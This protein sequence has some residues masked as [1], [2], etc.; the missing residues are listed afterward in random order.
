MKAKETNF[1]E[2][3][4]GPKQLVIPIY[5]RTYSWTRKQCQQL[6]DDMLRVATRDDIPAHFIGSVVYISDGIYQATSIPRLLVIDG[7][8]RLTTLSLLLSALAKEMDTR[9]DS[10]AKRLR[11]YFLINNDE[12]NEMRYKLIL[13]RSDKDTYIQIIEGIKL[14]ER[15]SPH[16]HENYQFFENLIRS[17]NDDLNTLYHGISKLVI[18]DVSLNRDYDNPQLI[19]ESLNSTGLD[20]SQA[21]LIRNF[22]LM[23]LEGAQQDYLYSHYW[24]PMEHNFGHAQY[25]EMFDRF[26][27]DYLTIKSEA[28]EI[29]A[30]RNVYSEFKAYSRGKN[31]NELVEDI[32]T[33]SRYF[34]NLAFPDRIADKEI[35]TILYDINTLKVDVAYP[36]L[37]EMYHDYE[38]TGLLTREGFIEILLLVESYVLR[39][40]ICGIPAN[41]MNKTFATLK[42]SIRKDDYLNSVKYALLRLSG[43]RRFPLDEEFWHTFG[44]TDV[45]NLR[46]RRNYILSKL[47][48]HNRKEFVNVESYT[49]EHIMPQNP[50]LSE[51][52]RAALGENWKELHHKYLHTIGNLTLTG[53]NPELSDKPFVFKR[54]TEGGFADSPIRLNRDLAHLDTWN[55]QQICNRAEHLADLAIQIWAEPKLPANIYENYL[56][57]ETTD[58]V[59]GYTLDNY[60]YLEGDILDLY[61]ALRTRIFNLDSSVREVFTSKYIAFKTITNFVDIQPQRRRLR[62]WINMRFEDVNDPNGI[63]RNVSAVG[64]YGNGEAEFGIERISDIEYAMY[65]IRQSF[66]FYSDEATL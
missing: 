22:I 61:H 11:N 57:T 21:D 55:E 34:I 39:R 28:G 63:C 15:H 30:I 7:Q 41:S 19:F 50:K 49:I 18:V 27:R 10:D 46:L 52:W 43:Y 16:I 60:E 44:I 42:R 20:L 25:S 24:Y 56:R 33:Y 4:R 9:G 14:D 32:H 17:N 5:Q 37:I 36:L 40:A 53:Y 59:V 26:M 38:E 8:Q 45:Y 6:W 51:E 58:E 29:P 31:V 54:D 48:N 47:E 62:L 23:G 13:T 12:E 65:L 35:A 64:H 66:D 2:F 3:L 1:L